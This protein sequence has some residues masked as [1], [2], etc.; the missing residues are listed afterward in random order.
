M[1]RRAVQYSLSATE[2]LTVS[3]VYYCSSSLLLDKN[4]VNHAMLRLVCVTEHN[5]SAQKAKGF[6]TRNVADQER[7]YSHSRAMDV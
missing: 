4:H 3:D 7:R 5:S 2:L 1:A 6:V